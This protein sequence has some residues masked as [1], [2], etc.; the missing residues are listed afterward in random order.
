M[1]APGSRKYA[2]MSENPGLFRTF[3]DLDSSPASLVNFADK[4]GLL[5]DSD[6]CEPVSIWEEAITRMRTVVLLWEEKQTSA[7]RNSSCKTIVSSHFKV[8]WK[9]R[10]ANP[11]NR[12]IEGLVADIYE[13]H[14]LNLTNSRQAATLPISVPLADALLKCNA[15][16]VHAQ[17]PEIIAAEINQNL[18]NIRPIFANDP[19]DH[20]LRLE[21][22]PSNLLEAMWLQFGQAAESGKSLRKCPQCDTW[23]E[24]FPKAARADKVFCGGACKAK[25]YRYRF[26]L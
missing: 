9:K 7:P 14:K 21:L 3:I 4:F 12:E 6:R 5:T 13:R 8:D 18:S 20:G 19:V 1:E 24:V 11:P 17:V 25:A 10:L 15:S 23:F 22:M 26:Y 16:Q 2:P